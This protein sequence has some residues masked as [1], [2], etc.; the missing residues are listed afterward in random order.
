MKKR[1]RRPGKGQPERLALP[2]FHTQPS[3]QPVAGKTKAIADRDCHLFS[4]ESA[5]ASSHSPPATP[6]Y[7]IDDKNFNAHCYKFL[8]SDH[9]AS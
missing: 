1:F 4:G 9:P 2:F 8:D 5:K 7:P 3:K 6:V